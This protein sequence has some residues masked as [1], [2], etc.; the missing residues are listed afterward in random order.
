MYPFEIILKGNVFR[1]HIGMQPEQEEQN[2]EM[3]VKR[4]KQELLD[5]AE[6]DLNLF[7]FLI[8]L[9]YLAGCLVLFYA[10]EEETAEAKKGQEEANKPKEA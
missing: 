4:R 7:F 6:A 9:A 1:I 3:A 5:D 8:F 2:P 10:R